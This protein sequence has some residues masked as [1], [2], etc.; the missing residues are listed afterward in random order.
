MKK[1]LSRFGQQSMQNTM[2]DDE[3]ED[4]KKFEGF[5]DKPKE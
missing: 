4:E 2:R 5:S 3:K 1:Q